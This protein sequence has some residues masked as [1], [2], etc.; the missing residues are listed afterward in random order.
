MTTLFLEVCEYATTVFSCAPHS[1]HGPAHWHR[2]DRFAQA[3]CQGTGADLTVV[4]FFAFLHDSRRRDDGADPGHG[5]RAADRLKALPGR[6]AVLDAT[7]LDLLE[8][9]IRHHTDGTTSPDPTVGACWD[10]DRL[11]LGRVGIIPSV[12]F[13]STERGR[14]MARHGPSIDRQ[15]RQAR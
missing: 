5:P 10:A 14:E 1:I 11:D 12:R 13:M 8:H 9:A 15:S 3:L 7:Q 6:L 4:R 2:V